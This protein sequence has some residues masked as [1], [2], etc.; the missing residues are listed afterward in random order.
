MGGKRMRALSLRRENRRRDEARDFGGG[1]L[2]GLSDGVGGRLG[3]RSRNA[4]RTRDGRPRRRNF[5]LPLWI[6]A[7]GSQRRVRGTSSP[8]RTAVIKAPWKDHGATGVSKEFFFWRHSKLFAIDQV[9]GDKKVEQGVGRL[10][11]VKWQDD[12]TATAG[13]RTSGKSLDQWI[14]ILT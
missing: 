11:K 10:G 5:L 2:D 6:N 14:P 13:A 7:H 12:A 3:S 1:G 8:T 4:K 9:V